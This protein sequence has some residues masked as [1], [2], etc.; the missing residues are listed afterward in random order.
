MWPGFAQVALL[1]I[2]QRPGLGYSLESSRAFYIMDII[3]AQKIFMR[4]S[5]TWHLLYILYV[6]RKFPERCLQGHSSINFPDTISII[7]KIVCTAH[8]VLRRCS[9]FIPSALR[10]VPRYANVSLIH[11]HDN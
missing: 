4:Q 11:P 2:Y 9:R 1:P 3:S 6:K 7:C 10:S 5:G 8:T